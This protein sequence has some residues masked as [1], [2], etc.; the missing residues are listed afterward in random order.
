MITLSCIALCLHRPQWGTPTSC[1]QSPTQC[2]CHKLTSALP[3]FSSLARLHSPITRGNLWLTHVAW[4]RT[5]EHLKASDFPSPSS[6][7]S[8]SSFFL[9]LFLLLDARVFCHSIFCSIFEGIY[10]W[11]KSQIC[12]SFGSLWRLKWM[13]MKTRGSFRRLCTCLCVKICVQTYICASRSASEFI[14][15][16]FLFWSLI[17]VSR[18]MC[19]CCLRCNC[20]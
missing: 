13:F 19:N 7:S 1:K 17:L 3:Q 2:D 14:Y 15:L 16:W 9:F 6:S 5:A 10:V 20:P 12:Q 4:P 18:R 8:S 11:D